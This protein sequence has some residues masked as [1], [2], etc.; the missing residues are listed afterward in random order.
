MNF[1]N[2]DSSLLASHLATKFI[3]ENDGIMIL[4]GSA[5]VYE[6]PVNFAFAY[7]VAKGAVH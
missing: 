5:S 6:G 1:A 2:V 4:T 7:G 3:S